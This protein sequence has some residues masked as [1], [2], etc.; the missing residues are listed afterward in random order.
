MRQ[1]YPLA[2]LDR[3][4]DVLVVARRI[5]R[6]RPADPLHHRPLQ[7]RFERRAADWRKVGQFLAGPERDDQFGGPCDLVEHGLPLGRGRSLVHRIDNQLDV[8]GDIG[9]QAIRH[10]L[11]VPRV[12]H[13]RGNDLHQ[14]QRDHDQQQRTAEHRLR[15]QPLQP[16]LPARLERFRSR[17]QPGA[18]NRTWFAQGGLTRA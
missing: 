14:H 15:Q 9:R 3:D 12:E 2:E 13:N 16:V 5:D 6:K 17:D 4:Q 10:R 1:Q 7:L 11:P 18:G 8:A